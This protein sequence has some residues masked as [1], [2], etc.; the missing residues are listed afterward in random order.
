MWGVGYYFS[1][2]DKYFGI[3]YPEH[4]L[5]R[6][7]CQLALA[8]DMATKLNKMRDIVLKYVR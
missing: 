7:R 1:I 8:L 6:S 5:V 2:K 3:S 4:N